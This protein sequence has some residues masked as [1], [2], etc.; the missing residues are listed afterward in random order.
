MED[1]MWIEDIVESIYTSSPIFNLSKVMTHLVSWILTIR[2]L[3]KK[4]A[5]LALPSA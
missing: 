3:F 1:M 5:F 4:N 2:W